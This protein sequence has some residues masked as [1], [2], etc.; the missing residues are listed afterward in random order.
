MT[1][2]ASWHFANWGTGMEKLLLGVALLSTF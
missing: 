2:P 1:F